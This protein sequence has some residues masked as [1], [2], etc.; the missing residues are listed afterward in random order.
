[1]NNNADPRDLM[2]NQLADTKNIMVDNLGKIR[3]MGEAITGHA[4]DTSTPDIT[5]E[6][7][8]GLFAFDHDRVGGHI[9]EADLT[10]DATTTDSVG[11]DILTDSTASWSINDSLE[12]ATIDNTTDGSTASITANTGTTVTGTL[13][14]GT[15]NSWDTAADDAYKINAVNVNKVVIL[16]CKIVILNYYY[17]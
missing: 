17:N 7:G 11:N 15:D 9:D 3:V 10:G 6:P 16:K 1:M 13:S 8:Y 4:A 5:V 14:G 12:G 2:E